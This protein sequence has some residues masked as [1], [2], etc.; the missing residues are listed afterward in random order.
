MNNTPS[1][2]PDSGAIPRDR[3]TGIAG[4][5]ILLVAAFASL[6]GSATGRCDG[7]DTTEP[8][9]SSYQLPDFNDPSFVPSDGDPDGCVT[10]TQA[11]AANS[12]LCVKALP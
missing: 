11:E 2:T 10:L 5:A 7:S 3:R 8:M 12:P 9:S 6:V 1:Q 4:K